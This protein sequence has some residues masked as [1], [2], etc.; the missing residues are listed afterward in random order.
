[1]IVVSDTSPV[2]ALIRINQIQL[3]PTLFHEVVIPT[4]VR[5]ELSLARFTEEELIIY[6]S[7]NWL[8]E[9]TVSNTV[10]LNADLDKGE[11]EAIVLAK[12]L[13]ADFL[14]IDETAG[15]KVAMNEGVRIIGVIGLLLVAK[16]KGL[17]TEVKILIDALIAKSDF[18]IS[19]KLYKNVLLQAGE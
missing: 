4:A 15:R 10:I 11:A 19:E 9:K 6:K 17:I 12:Q 5:E 14:L 13:H 1:M 3:L 8:I 7:C 18:W 2:I 16:E